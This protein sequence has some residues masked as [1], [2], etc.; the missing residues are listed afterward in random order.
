MTL[1]DWITLVRLPLALLFLIPTWW[2]RTLVLGLALL[3]DYLDGLI[4]RKR[5]TPSRIGRLLDP[6]ADKW[7][8]FFVSCVFW[9]EGVLTLG[10]VA[11]LFARD[12]ALLTFGAYLLFTGRW[13]KSVWRPIWW[14]KIFTVVQICFLVLLTWKVPLPSF[15]FYGFWIMG[16]FSLRELL[17]RAK[18]PAS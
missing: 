14:G 3:S 5:N 8:V 7:F 11:A 12:W 17:Q 2:S 16:I 13:A 10:Q 15:L 4:A 9:S 18:A 6:I 1:S